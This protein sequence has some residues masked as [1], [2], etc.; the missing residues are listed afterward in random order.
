MNSKKS[1]WLSLVTLGVLSI[2]VW[3]TP[4]YLIETP[5][6]ARTIYACAILLAVILLAPIVYRNYKKRRSSPKLT[7]DDYLK[8]AFLTG[9]IAV[10]YSILAFFH[11]EYRHG[12]SMNW[13]IPIGWT[14]TTVI[15]LWNASKAEK[16]R[17]IPNE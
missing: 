3:V 5:E 4:R 6:S 14:V 7:R 13:M 12:S 17:Y 9:G 2:F 16:T 8:R 10:A 15:H 1:F 11:P